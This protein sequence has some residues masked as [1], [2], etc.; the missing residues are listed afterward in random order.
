LPDPEVI[1][2]TF[3]VMAYVPGRIFWDP[4][5]PELS[6]GARAAVYDDMNRVIARL[7]RVDFVGAGLADFGRPGNYLER[8]IARWSKQYLASQTEQIEAME[9]LI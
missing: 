5:L 7:H 3:F 6:R 8:Q 1:G 2:A 4:T 9:G